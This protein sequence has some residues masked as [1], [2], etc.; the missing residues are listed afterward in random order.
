MELP[1]YRE[2]Y[3]DLTERFGQG[4][5]ISIKEVAE[6]DKA[7]PRTVCKR[8]GIPKGTKGINKAI[9]ARRICELTR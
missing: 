8:Y 9:L 1:G 7:D 6:Y 5:W 2:V 4:A 3:S